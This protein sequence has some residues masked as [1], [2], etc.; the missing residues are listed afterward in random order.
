[1][2]NKPV[3]LTR[4]ERKVYHV[5]KE[6]LAENFQPSYTDLGQLADVS[7]PTVAKAIKKL[8]ELK[9]IEVHRQGQ[10]QRNLYSLPED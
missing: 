7:N 1:M 2:E 6:C 8:E 9:M 10:G 4:S 3:Y 5:I